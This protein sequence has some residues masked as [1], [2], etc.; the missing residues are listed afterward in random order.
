MVT[1]IGPRERFRRR[2]GSRPLLA[3]GAMGT[4]LFSRGV[5]QRASLDELATSRPELVGATH[6]EYLEAGAELIE[7]LTLGANRLRLAPFGLAERTSRLNRRA[8]QLAREAREVSGRDAL[9]GGSM[10]PLVSVGQ[11]LARLTDAEV[12]AAFREQLDGLLEGGIDVVILETFSD[13]PTLLLAMDEARAAS[14]LPILASLT[15]GED[16][17]LIDGTTPESAVAAL[18]AAGADVIGVNCGAGP[19][20]CLDALER[21]QGAAAKASVALSIMPNAGLPQRIE[22]QFVYAADPA[23]FGDVAPRMLEAGARIIG[24]CCGTTP[25]HVRAMRAAL[26]VAEA[27]LAAGAGSGTP[28]AAAIATPCPAPP[29]HRGQG[30]RVH[31]GGG[32]P[33]PDAARRGVARGPLRGLGRDRP[34]AL[35][36]DRPHARCGAH[37]S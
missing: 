21:M 20:G 14:D 23:Y 19:V 34:A 29:V 36:P 3:D 22:G 28:A 17:A 6:R 12:R 32:C 10:G 5:P 1:P 8:A 16:V 27:A 35:H 31:L 4:L 33:A 37:P 26:D 2:L 25:D 15:F 24:G 11:E 7:T 30:R 13:L 9:V 18:L